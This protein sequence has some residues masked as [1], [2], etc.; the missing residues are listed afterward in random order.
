MVETE[1]MRGKS[2][3]KKKVL[4]IS[5]YFPPTNGADM[6][7]I[8]MSLPYFKEYG[9]EPTVVTVDERFAD[10]AKDP[11]L[12]QTVPADITV[13]KV[14]ALK[15]SITSKFGLGSIAYRALPYYLQLVNRILRTGEFQ[16]I[17]FS[18][19]QFPICL[20]GP[21]W[22]K[23]FKVP[24]VID[25]QDPW[26][27]DYY[28]DKPKAQQPKK[29]WLSY[30]LNKFLE[31]LALK[32]V[33]GLISVS[34]DYLKNL[35]ARYPQLKQIPSATITFG[36][37]GQDLEIAAENVSRFKP[38][39]NPTFKNIVCIGRGGIDMHAA[40]RP[41][42]ETLK[43]GLDDA[44]EFFNQL[45]IC[46]IGTSYAPEGQGTPT[47]LPLAREYDLGEHIV[48][49]TD[50]I[51]FY[52]ALV[53]L[54][55]ADALFIP[56]S[57][58]PKYTASKIYPY[59]LC[60]KPLLTVFNSASSAVNILNEF[61]SFHNYTYDAT[62]DLHSKIYHFLLMMLNGEFEPETYN[63]TAEEKYS[64]RNLTKQQCALFDRVTHGK[65]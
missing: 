58:D 42:L 10:L 14:K 40:I 20:L 34:A 12:S 21:Y 63:K 1:I 22:K 53:T 11:L 26:H 24:Y 52:H 36:A 19:T 46:F 37:L 2:T 39:L 59:L 25:M 23:R 38:L 32:D 49:I 33:D 18:T 65:N 17:Y 56:G 27:S 15:K 13:Y 62:P 8:R 9:W 41:I 3:H 48:E 45:R 29:Y 47:I 30:R 50:R 7:R 57:D 64:A 44:P 31:P 28:Q 51:S 54:Q 43:R 61:G 4:V 55:Q 6:Q 5:P 60:R 35:K 16:L